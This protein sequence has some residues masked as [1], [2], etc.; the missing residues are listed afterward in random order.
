MWYIYRWGKYFCTEWWLWTVCILLNI[1]LS[2]YGQ[3][4]QEAKVKI[5]I[6][7]ILD[8]TNLHVYLSVLCAHSQ[9]LPA[10]SN[11]NLLDLLLGISTSNQGCHFLRRILKGHLKN[12]TDSVSFVSSGRALQSSEPMS[13]K[14]QSPLFLNQDLP[15]TSKIPAWASEFELRLTGDQ[16]F[17]TMALSQAVMYFKGPEIHFFPFFPHSAS[18]FEWC[19]PS[20]LPKLQ[21]FCSF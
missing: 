9:Y 3:Y 13:A 19:G 5:R 11:V 20:S 8:E 17:S 21:L 1:M 10:Q 18:N 4:L 2:Q 15:N 14:T 12:V 16:Q 6:R 7:T